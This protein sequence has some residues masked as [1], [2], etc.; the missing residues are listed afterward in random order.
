MLLGASIITVSALL[1]YFV[2]IL[3]VGKARFKY[4]V[5]PPAMSGDENFERANNS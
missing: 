3:N 4:N 1:V 2:T 5:L